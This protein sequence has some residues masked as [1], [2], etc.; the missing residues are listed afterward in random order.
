MHI[1]IWSSLQNCCRSIKLWGDLL[2][3]AVKSFHI[4]FRSRLWLGHYKTE[5]LLLKTFLWWVWFVLWVII[6]LV[7]DTFFFIFSCL[8]EV[9]RFCA[10]KC[11]FGAI[12]NFLLPRDQSQ[13]K[14][15][16]TIAWSCRHHALL[17]KC[18]PLASCCCRLLAAPCLG[19]LQL[20]VWFTFLILVRV[21]TGFPS[22]HNPTIL[23][24]HVTG[25]EI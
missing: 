11:W 20:I 1:L 24:W 16:N 5:P 17:C 6:M 9:C 12:Q 3:T 21:Y 15:C 10:K 8:T 22:W 13:L 18:W 2:C 25:T 19:L 7:R 23:S 14:R 4:G